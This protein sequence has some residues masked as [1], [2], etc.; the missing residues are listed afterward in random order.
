VITLDPNQG[1]FGQAVGQLV[2]QDPNRVKG[3]ILFFFTVIIAEIILV[4][5]KKQFEKVQLSEM[6]F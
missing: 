3:M 4:I 6:N 1:G 5:K 2:F